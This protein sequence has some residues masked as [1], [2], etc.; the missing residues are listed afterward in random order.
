MC[1]LNRIISENSMLIHKSDDTYSIIWR[2][3]WRN[4]MN[5]KFNDCFQRITDHGAAFRQAEST[6]IAC[7]RRFHFIFPSSGI[8]SRSRPAWKARREPSG[9]ERR[10]IV[11]RT[12]TND[13]FFRQVP[14]PFFPPRP[15]PVGASARRNEARLV[16]N[17]GSFALFF[18]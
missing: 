12:E 1:P 17:V 18:A 3:H 6:R 7:F 2:I 15:C 10:K 16:E 5:N 4:L 11:A 9:S 14:P 13:A 8:V